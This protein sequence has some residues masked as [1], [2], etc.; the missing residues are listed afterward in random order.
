MGGTVGS[1]VEITI[2]G[3]FI[4]DADEL[5]FLGRSHLGQTQTRPNG[6]KQTKASMLLPSPPIVLQGFYEARVMTRLGLSTSRVF[7]VGILPEAIQVRPNTSLDQAMDLTINSICNAVMS[8]KA[9]DHYRFHAEQNKRY[10]IDCAAKAIDSK[11]E[12]VLI[13]ADAEGKDLLVERRGGMLD[14]TAPKDGPFV[15]KVHELTFKGG[16]HYFY[17]LRLQELP[18]DAPLPES[19][20]TQTVSFFFLAA[21]GTWLS[22]GDARVGA[23]QSRKRGA[24]HH[25]AG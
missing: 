17:R 4:D 2:A 8:A 10:V 13:V 18:A 16:P 7:S 21:A 23:E 25:F 6:G 11:L 3:D 14:F 22:G 20:S 12:P 24:V 5:L 15:I 9:V 1:Q 19:D